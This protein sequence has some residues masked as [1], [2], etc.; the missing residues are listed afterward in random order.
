MPNTN[1]PDESWDELARELGLERSSPAA[2]EVVLSPVPAAES[3]SE[4]DSEVAPARGE[5]ED[6]ESL[7]EFE[8]IGEEAEL[9]EE[10]AEGE[11]AD[12]ELGDEGQPGTGRKRRRRRR[13]RKKG[14]G[15]AAPAA[16]ETGTAE[17]DETGEDFTVTARIE[18]DHLVDTDEESGEPE[19][20]E[21]AVEVGAE[22]EDVGGEVLRELTANWNVPSWDEIVGGLYRPER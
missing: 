21:V 8:T 13:R 14:G 6:L 9:V 19:D 7:E 16:A 5:A 22:E 1:T 20:E 10:G 4:Q 3:W 12:G 15:A 18:D 17:A 2:D 11:A